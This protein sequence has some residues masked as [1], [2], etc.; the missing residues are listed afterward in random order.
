VFERTVMEQVVRLIVVGLITG[1][2]SG[3]FGIGGALIGTPL[4]RVVAQ[5]PP[6]LALATPLPVAIP[7]A[8]SGAVAYWRRGLVDTVLAVQTLRVAV[9]MTLLGSA[10]THWTSGAVL[11]AITALVLLYVAWSMLHT[12]TLESTQQR[13]PRRIALASAVAGFAAGFLAIGGGIVL[14]PVYVRWLGVPI[15]RALATSLVCVA[16]MALPGT[17]VHA[18]LGHI[19]WPAAA[20]LAIAAL[21]ASALGA[22]LALRIKSR[23]LERTYA[24]LLSA[25]GLWFLVRTLSGQ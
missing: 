16:T 9:P 2:S 17:I 7:S 6:L 14:V 11:M 20:L 22:Q 4:L 5:L 12:P 25:F 21:P 19:D 18:A 15:H 8:I 23:T 13:S 24:A 1:V 10:L 3:L